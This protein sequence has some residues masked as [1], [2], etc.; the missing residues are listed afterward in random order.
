MLLGAKIIG[1]NNR[2][3][4]TLK[5]D[6][7]TSFELV[8]AIPDDCIAVCESGI[9]EGAEIRRLRAAGFDAFLIG[10]HLMTQADPGAGLAALIASASFSFADQ[11]YDA[12]EN[13]RNYELGG[14]E[15]V[16]GCGGV[17]DRIKFLCAESA[18]GESCGSVGN[19]SEVAAVR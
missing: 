17:G 1:V 5:V 6:L 15:G 14:R 11:H 19:C 7:A 10:E 18:V 2:D 12:R 9:R 4:K 13:L 3:L 16:R 8:K